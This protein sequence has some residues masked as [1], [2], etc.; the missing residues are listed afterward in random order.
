MNLFVLLFLT[1]QFGL[2]ILMFGRSK[3]TEDIDSRDNS[4]IASE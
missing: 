1:T 4:S 2:L 3:A